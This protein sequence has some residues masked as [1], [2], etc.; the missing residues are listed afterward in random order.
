MKVVV[1][2]NESDE[3]YKQAYTI[4][5]EEI[6]YCSQ[7]K[8]SSHST[9]V[10]AGASWESPKFSFGKFTASVNTKFNSVIADDFKRAKTIKTSI[11]DKG[12]FDV[13]P[14][15]SVIRIY[16]W[17]T[18]YT[19]QTLTDGLGFT[20][21]M[22]FLTSGPELELVD[23]I[24][25]SDAIKA[26]KGVYSKKDWFIHAQYLYDG[27]QAERYRNLVL[28]LQNKGWLAADVPHT[29]PPSECTD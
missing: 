26:K 5:R 3:V 21:D 15:E 28:Y 1:K 9:E 8:H 18:E 7:E 22:G 23:I 14:W 2:N 25:F 13:K 10:E 6:V 16:H 20:Q 24:A 12:T 4:D 19:D 29:K 17:S 11:S 27:L